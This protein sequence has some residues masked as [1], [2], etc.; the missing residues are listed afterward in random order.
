MKREV[1]VSYEILEMTYQITRRHISEDRDIDID[2]HMDTCSL[3]NHKKNG[4]LL[5]VITTYKRGQNF[6]SSSLKTVT[7]VASYPWFIISILE[8]K[9]C[10]GT[11]AALTSEG[12]GLNVW[13]IMKGE[14]M[15]GATHK[16]FK[17]RNIYYGGNDK[18]ID[19]RAGT[20]YKFGKIQLN[21]RL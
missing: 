6:T 7:R 3:W 19:L 18:Q 1:A 13:S 21:S 15:L 14:A 8:I 10:A 2:I 4:S 12:T 17:T 5:H 16:I 20:H 9:I 11:T